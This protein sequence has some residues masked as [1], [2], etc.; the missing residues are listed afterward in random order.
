MLRYVVIVFLM[1]IAFVACE[2]TQPKPL[3]ERLLDKM[4][5]RCKVMVPKDQYARC[6]NPPGNT[7][8]EAMN[9]L[10]NIMVAQ[11][12]A[13]SP[14]GTCSKHGGYLI[15]NEKTSSGTKEVIYRVSSAND[16]SDSQIL[17]VWSEEW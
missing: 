15:C 9:A 13:L 16:G 2:R 6:E 8:R 5:Q 3:A 17:S 14:E 4:I 11:A 12:I 1:A 10:H 7:V